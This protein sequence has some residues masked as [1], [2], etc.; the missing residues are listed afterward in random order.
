MWL[1]DVLEALDLQQPSLL[2]GSYGAGILLRAAAYAPERIGKA[3]LFIPS[4]LVSIPPSTMLYLLWWL[5]LYRL[6]PSQERLERVLRPMFV[7]PVAGGADEP[8]DEE[9]LE[10]TEAVFRL[11][12]IEPEMPRNVRRG[13]LASFNA[14]TLVIA[15]EKDALFPAQGVIRR[16]GEVFPNLVSA[17]VIP[18][19]AH[20]LPAR[21]HPFL[22]ERIQRFLERVD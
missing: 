13:E 9:V 5:A 20:Y 7:P 3:A 8:I 2:G 16:A 1:V 6:A 15:A 18:G 12:R 10:I 17:E 14:P 22:N 19:A 4:G 21:C 11:V